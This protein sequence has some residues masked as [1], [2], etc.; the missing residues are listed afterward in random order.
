MA[1]FLGGNMNTDIK[2]NMDNIKDR[3]IDYVQSQIEADYMPS[4][5]YSWIEHELLHEKGECDNEQT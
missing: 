3:Y 5:Y 2:L 4:D 1:L